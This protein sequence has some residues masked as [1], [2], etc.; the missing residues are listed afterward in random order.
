MT[1]SQEEKKMKIKLFETHFA[2]VNESLLQT[3]TEKTGIKRRSQWIKDVVKEDFGITLS[4]PSDI[5]KL[6]MIVRSQFYE[7]K[8]EWLRERMRKEIRKSR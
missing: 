4:S 7:D 1:V 2:W 3:F 8:G 5:P 6:D